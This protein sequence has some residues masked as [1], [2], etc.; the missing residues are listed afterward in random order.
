MAMDEI[1]SPFTPLSLTAMEIECIGFHVGLAATVAQR[2]KK[3]HYSYDIQASMYVHLANY[4]CYKPRLVNVA[5][6]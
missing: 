4:S 2:H 5:S 3:K 6:S 1:S